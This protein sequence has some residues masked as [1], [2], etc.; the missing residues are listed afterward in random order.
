MIGQ[1]LWAAVVAVLLVAV[2]VGWAVRG[3]MEVNERVRSPQRRARRVALEP[4]LL[5]TVSEP[6][7]LFASA[8]LLSFALLFLTRSMDRGLP[9]MGALVLSFTYAVLCA[10]A[11]GFIVWVQIQRSADGRT[12]TQFESFR[13]AAWVGVGAGALAVIYLAVD[14]ITNLSD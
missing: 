14:V 7:A 8:F 10:M 4:E 1:I 11:T 2:A 9:L 5:R 13:W 3:A 12:A 6:R